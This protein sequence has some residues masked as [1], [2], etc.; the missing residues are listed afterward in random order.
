[1]SV[2]KRVGGDDERRERKERG[3]G[4][5]GRTNFKRVNVTQSNKGKLTD[6][7]QGLDCM[8]CGGVA[9]EK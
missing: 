3:R 4:G 5:N 8:A 9:T 2:R 7:W 1:M 6:W